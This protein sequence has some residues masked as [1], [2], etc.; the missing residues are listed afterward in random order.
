MARRFYEQVTVEPEAGGFAVLLDTKTVLSPGKRALILPSE[1]LARSIADEWTG[2]G[3]SIEPASMRLTRLANS[4]LDTAVER[5][6]M[7]IDDIAKYG[8]TDLV[9]YR[10]D[11][12]EALRRRQ[13]AAWD[14]LIVWVGEAHGA[15]LVV[16]TGL[17][18]AA[19]PDAALQSI[20]RAVEGFDAFG[21]TAL[22]AA[23]AAL[24]SVVIA[25]AMAATRISVEEA[26]HAGAIEEAFQAD[27]WGEDAD[28]EARRANLRDDLAAAHRFLMLC[29]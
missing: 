10:V 3:E 27:R 26:W 13:D 9:C 14:P 6:G 28:A 22:H 25:L 21:L 24:G 17:L 7:V 19:Q 12:P 16:T 11:G 15:D 20:R 18:P 2:Q 1:P 29:P 23:T 5:R 4:A 8:D